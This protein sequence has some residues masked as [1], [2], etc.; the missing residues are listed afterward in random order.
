MEFVLVT[1]VCFFITCIFEGEI[2]Q[3]M[4]DAQILFL[5]ALSAILTA[6]S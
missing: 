6:D 1:F 5:P 3:Q 4:L 2:S